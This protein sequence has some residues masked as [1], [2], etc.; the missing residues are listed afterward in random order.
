MLAD[1]KVGSVNRSSFRGENIAQIRDSRP[2]KKIR[3]TENITLFLRSDR[4][5]GIAHH[6]DE[7]IST[8]SG[9]IGSSGRSVSEIAKG[10]SDSSES[11]SVFNDPSKEVNHLSRGRKVSGVVRTQV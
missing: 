2:N 6:V 9:G 4:V 10:H 11:H 3:R 1:K 7:A 8:V 5:R